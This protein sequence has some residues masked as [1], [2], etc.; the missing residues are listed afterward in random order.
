MDVFSKIQIIWAETTGLSVPTGGA[1]ETLIALRRQIA[2]IAEDS[3][4]SFARFD[5]VPA[6]DD[7]TTSR[8]LADCVAASEA[9]IVPE[10]RNK[11]LILWPSAD[12]KTL[13][14]TEATPPAPWDSIL[15]ADMQSLGRFQ[16]GGKVVTAFR[17]SVAAADTAPRFVS[18]VTGTG[19]DAGTEVYRPREMAARTVPATAKRW[20]NIWAVVAIVLFI[21]ASF[22]SMSVGT[23]ARL[24]EVQ[25]ARQLLAGAPNCSTV[26]D[27]TD[28]VSYFSL[29]AAWLHDDD[30]SCLA[31]WGK[32]VR[33]SFAAGGTDLWSKTVFWFASLSLSSTGLSFSIVLPTYAAMISMVLLAFSAGYGIVGRPLGLLIDS[34]NRMSLTRAQ[35][36]VWLIIIMGGLTSTALFNTGFWGGDMARV[37]EGLA[38]MSDLARNDVAL[39]DVPLM[40]SRLSEFVPQMDAALWA[41]I[42]ITAG[43]TILSS[44]MVKNDDNATGEVTRRTRLL[45]NDSPDDAQLSDLVYGETVQADGVIDYSRVQTVAITGLLAA[46]YTGLILQAGQNLGG[47]TATS[48]VEFG[49][50]VF[51]TMPPAGG[52]FLLLLGASHATLL[53]SKLQGLLR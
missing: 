33:T 38:K 6:L 39:K 42:G 53:A 51:A 28:A 48:A 36:S 11:A 40:L 46:I 15:A 32:A 1:A 12:G 47:L 20:S 44:L 5:P 43:T 8:D 37:Q 52:T 24:S 18:L 10:L 17:R 14:T 25:F 22:W 34:R 35:F 2:A 4:G 13:S 21:V 30:K 23:V 41:L 45:K 3:P 49:H 27:A 16:I 19:L 50:Q 7:V 26:T 9:Q 29:P 31:E